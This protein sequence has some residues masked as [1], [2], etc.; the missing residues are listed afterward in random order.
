MNF[1]R[2]NQGMI[3]VTGVILGLLVMAYSIGVGFRGG[4]PAAYKLQVRPVAAS[5]K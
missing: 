1:L 5:S 3:L 2:D 4:Q